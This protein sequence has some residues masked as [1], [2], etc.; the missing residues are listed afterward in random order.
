MG[1]T[2]VL[3]AIEPEAA[4]PLSVELVLTKWNIEAWLLTAHLPRRRVARAFLI[5]VL[6]IG[7]SEVAAIPISGRTSAEIAKAHTARRQALAILEAYAPRY[8]ARLPKGAI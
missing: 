8:M 4:V 2:S 7:R 5:R 1:E 6:E 3:T